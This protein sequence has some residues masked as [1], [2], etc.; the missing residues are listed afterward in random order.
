[1]RGGKA[2]DMMIEE[3][4]PVR[5]PVTLLPLVARFPLCLW[6]YSFGFPIHAKFRKSL[7]PRQ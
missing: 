4:N 2:K 5:D 6:L 7:E 1:M 3:L